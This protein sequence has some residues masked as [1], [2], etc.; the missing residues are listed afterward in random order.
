MNTKIAWTVN[1]L[2]IIVI[3]ALSCSYEKLMRLRDQNL[4]FVSKERYIK[5]YKD[6]YAIGSMQGWKDGA[7]MCVSQ[8]QEKDK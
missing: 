3:S 8:K 4:M 2:L 1:V 5:G 6:G 7:V